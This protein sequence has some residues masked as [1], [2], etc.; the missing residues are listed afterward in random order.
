MRLAVCRV[1]VACTSYSNFRTS[2]AV[3]D[4]EPHPIKYG[5]CISHLPIIKGPD[6]KTCHCVKNLPL[7]T[8]LPWIV[9][10]SHVQIN[11][12]CHIIFVVGLI[13]LVRDDNIC[14]AYRSGRRTGLERRGLSLLAIRS[15][16]MLLSAC[17]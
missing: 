2:Q 17:G 8:P 3:R 6:W 15:F 14:S 11:Y 10:F 9:G 5:H 7:R 13:L 16:L 12:F 4:R 1:T